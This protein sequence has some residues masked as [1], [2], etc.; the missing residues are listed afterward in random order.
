MS[1]N[2]RTALLAATLAVLAVTNPVHATTPLEAIVVTP[3]DGQT[4]DRAR[5]D[6]YEC[7]NWAVEQTG[8][9]PAQPVDDDA[10]ADARAERVDRVIT[11][12]AVGGAIGGLIRSSRRD[13]TGKGVLAGSAVG[14]AVGALTGR[15]EGK[16]EEDPAFDSYYRALSA[17]LEARHYVV[18]KGGSEDSG[19]GD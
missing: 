4:S 9:V 8:V 11:G 18:S 12:A 1:S 3:Q 10:D 6:R 17:C 14:A 2:S 13:N 15:R 16:D 5:R 19:D 7:H